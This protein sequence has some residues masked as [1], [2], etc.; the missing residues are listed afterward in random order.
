MCD[1]V[2]MAPG[3][4]SDPDAKYSSSVDARPMSTTST[5]AAVT[6]SANARD[7]SVPDARMSRARTILGPPVKAAKA[8]PT[9]RARSA[10]S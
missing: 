4:S 1:A 9:D 2:N 10:F 6:P 8:T 7:S 5:P 3:A